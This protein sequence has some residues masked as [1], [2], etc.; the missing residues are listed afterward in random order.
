MKRWTF[1]VV[2]CAVWVAI[3]TPAYNAGRG[4]ATRPGVVFAPDESVRGDTGRNGSTS[5]WKRRLISTSRFGMLKWLRTEA[6]D[7]SVRDEAADVR[8]PAVNQAAAQVQL[9]ERVLET[10]LQVVRTNALRREEIDWPRVELRVR[11]RAAGALNPSEVY[12]AIRYLLAELGDGHSALLEP[13]EVVAWASARNSDPEVLKIADGIAYM[14]LYRYLGNDEQRARSYAERMYA[15]FDDLKLGATCGWIIDLRS[16][17]GGNM[18]PMLAALKPFLGRSPIGKFE[19]PNGSGVS[20]SAGDNVAA[21]A[22]GR[23]ALLESSW[24]AV[25]IGPGTASSGE[26]VAVAFQG[27]SRTRSF[28]MPTAGLSTA[29]DMFFLPDGAVLVLTT[30]VDVD[31]NGRRYGSSLEPDERVS[32]AP[33]AAEDATISAAVRWLRA[34]SGCGLAGRANEPFM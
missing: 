6:T 5:E 2:H 3:G 26:A 32:E 4:D 29:N 22:P 16:D 31:R 13:S 25:L 21:D 14:H 10:A 33:S 34:S 12:S 23:L 9:A 1:I 18:W 24:V 7:I 8:E 15:L 11:A 27:R 28:G 20:W 30:G 19:G 17:V